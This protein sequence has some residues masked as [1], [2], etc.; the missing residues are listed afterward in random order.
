MGI[1][2]FYLN[3]YFLKFILMFHRQVGLSHQLMK[4]IFSNNRKVCR[5]VQRMC[6]PQRPAC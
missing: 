2:H 6:G 4:G 3:E 5:K 1:L